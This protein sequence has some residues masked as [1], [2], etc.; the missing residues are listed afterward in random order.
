MTGH[1]S[2]YNFYSAPDIIRM[3]RS[4]GNKPEEHIARMLT[5]I[6]TY[7]DLSGEPEGRRLVKDTVK[8]KCVMEKSESLLISLLWVTLRTSGGVL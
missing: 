5:V 1:S 6:D 2:V 4:I 8:T 3:S 7:R